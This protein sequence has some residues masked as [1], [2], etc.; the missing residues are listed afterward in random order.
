MPAQQV[1]GAQQQGGRWRHR[2]HVAPVAAHIRAELPTPIVTADA[3]QRDTLD[4]LGVGIRQGIAQDAG[5]CLTGCIE[6]VLGD[7]AQRRGCSREHWR[8]VDARHSQAERVAGRPI[9]AVDG[10][11]GNVVDAHIIGR[12]GAT[13]GASIGIEIQPAGQRGTADEIGGVAHDAVAEVDL[14]KGP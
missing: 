12:R 7:W 4:C 14:S 5:H 8:V 2:A 3:L 13:E 6:V 1:G 11:D 10:R 9:G